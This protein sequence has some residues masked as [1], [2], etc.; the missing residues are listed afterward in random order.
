MATSCREYLVNY[1][2]S[3]RAL[4]DLSGTSRTTLFNA[5]SEQSIVKIPRSIDLR[6]IVAKLF[7][8]RG[9]SVSVILGSLDH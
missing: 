2:N 6:L 8:R 5:N 7:A 9:W 1:M 3:F 4:A